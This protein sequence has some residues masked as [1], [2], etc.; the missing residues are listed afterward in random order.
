MNHPVGDNEGTS[1]YVFRDAFLGENTVVLDNFSHELL[2]GFY[3]YTLNIIN[4]VGLLNNVFDILTVDNTVPIP[5]SIGVHID[6]TTANFLVSGELNST[7][8]YNNISS[9]TN[10]K[11]IAT[12]MRVWWE[13]FID[14]EVPIDHYEI[15]IGDSSGEDNV[16]HFYKVGL[17]NEFLIQSLQ[18]LNYPYVWVTIRGVNLLGFAAAVTSDPIAISPHNPDP[19]SVDDPSFGSD[20]LTQTSTTYI[21]GEWDFGDP[22]LGIYYEWSVIYMNETTIQNLTRVTRIDS[23]NDNIYMTPETRV[24]LLV[25]SYSPLGYI[26]SGRSDP[27]SVEIDPLIPGLVFDGP[28]TGMDFNHQASLVTL[29]ANWNSFGG[30]YHDK[31]SQTVHKYEMA[32][33]T[34]PRGKDLFNILPFMDVN[35]T[36][37]YTITNL[38]LTINNTYYITIRATSATNQIAEVTSNGIKPIHFDRISQPGTVTIPHFQSTTTNINI[39]WENFTSL[40][41]FIYYQYGVSTDGNLTFLACNGSNAEKD[42]GNYLNIHPFTKA[43]TTNSVVLSYLNLEMGLQYFAYVRTIDDAFQCSIAVSN[44]LTVDTTPPLTGVFSIGFDTRTFGRDI[45][46]PQISYVTT[47]DSL[48]VSWSGFYDPE[49]SVNNYQIA[50]LE[51]TTCN[52]NSCNQLTNLTTFFT[53]TNVTNHTFYVID[54]FPGYFYF[55]ALRPINRAGL[56]TCVVSQPVVLDRD[57]PGIAV[58]KHG[59][60]WTQAPP[61]QG[62]TTSIRGVLALV[63]DQHDAVCMDRVYNASTSGKDWN[64]I[65]Q[66]VTPTLPLGT[67]NPTGRTLAYSPTQVQFNKKD[68]FLE[69]SMTRD[70]QQYRMVSAAAVTEMSIVSFNEMSV[71]IKSAASFQAVTSVLI[72]DGPDTFIED[73]EISETNNIT[74]NTS[75]PINPFSLPQDCQYMPLPSA[76]PLPYKSFGLQLHPA[77]NSIPAR[78]LFWYRG[79]I[80]SQY[81]HTWLT[82]GFDPSFSYHTYHLTL[83]KVSS[84]TPSTVKT[85]TW[86]V[87]LKIDGL[88][89]A[90][91][92]DLPQFNNTLHFVLHVR[93][94]NGRVEPINNPFHPSTTAAYFSDII[95]PV[96]S[97]RVC[98]YG[99]PFYSPEAPFVKF[100]VGVGRSYGTTNLSLATGN[101]YQPIPLS[102]IPCNQ[103]CSQAPN[104]CNTSCNAT[105]YYIGFEATGLDLLPG[106]THPLNQTNTTCTPYSYAS[107]GISEDQLYL[108]NLMFVPYV[109][110]VKVRAYTR[111]GHVTFGYSRGIQLDPT[112]PNCTLIQHVQKDLRSDELSNT[113][114][115]YSSDSLAIQYQCRDT[116]SDIYGYEIA[117]SDNIDDIDTLKFSSVG[118]DSTVNITG[119]ELNPQL[120]YYVVVRATNGAGLSTILRSSGV[121]ILNTVPDVSRVVLTPRNSIEVNTLRQNSSLSKEQTSIGLRWSGF[122]QTSYQDNFTIKN[123]TLFWKIG[124]EFGRDD[125]LPA[126]E[127]NYNSSVS[128]RI[129]DIR[130]IGNTSFFVSNITDLAHLANNTEYIYEE[131]DLIMQVEP[132]RVLY[133]TLILCA[134]QPKCVSA[135]TH[136]ITIF[137]KLD[138]YYVYNSQDGEQFSLSIKR[139]TTEVNMFGEGDYIRSPMYPTDCKVIFSSDIIGN[140]GYLIGDLALDEMRVKYYFIS[141]PTSSPYVPYIVDPSSTLHL[142]DRFALSRVLEFYGPS[143]YLSPIGG[144]NFPSYLKMIIRINPIDFEDGFL[145]ILL[146]WNPNTRQW[147][148][149]RSSCNFTWEDDIYRESFITY[150]CPCSTDIEV[151]LN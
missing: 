15:G 112:P 114:V 70:I 108:H 105:T 55:L 117:Y 118:T 49:S 10:C 119:L 86:S 34:Q 37:T 21:E 1:E 133:Q 90:S 125:I 54:L 103:E 36:T 56:T 28:F 81:A 149:S 99:A 131:G 72:W 95:L 136:S 98:K 142:V 140:S 126:F 75:L 30:N 139:I 43:T 20:F 41:P 115:Q 48:S 24:Y 61:Y 6:Q 151:G 143:F 12:E 144:V 101:E 57:Q 88:S 145:P 74:S 26:K 92:V 130:V 8:N 124:N 66:D 7:Y 14:Y 96:D 2:S 39:A 73:Y 135:G 27:I 104:I 76:K 87:L 102:C 60:N 89:V 33:G 22:C 134:I 9:D 79:D 82:L 29:S 16:F 148:S 77:Y 62:S 32:A 78:A 69:I 107:T 17:V 52:L 42:L 91:L 109:Y 84:S 121:R 47:N 122:Y 67:N 100:E 83:E 53:L 94:Y 129:Q 25:N 110:Y 111:A 44:P 64:M 59:S 128:I 68:A 93:N 120:K 18:L 85:A 116:R 71:S 11:T 46:Q 80:N 63:T 97:T 19:P 146:G 132:G 137:K 31:L 141:A 51:E 65:I 23:Y 147:V 13:D 35:L 3:V 50:L 127:I 38:T 113:T 4:N 58:V 45:A 123:Q 106:C 5:R 40:L 138:E 150:F